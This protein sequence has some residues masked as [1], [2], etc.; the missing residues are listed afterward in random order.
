MQTIGEKI[1]ELRKG[2]KMTQEQL[3]E[4]MHVSSQ[5]VSKWENDLSIPDLP[6]LV[7]LADYFQVSL[8]EIVRP[9]KEQPVRYVDQVTKKPMEQMTLHIYVLSS[10][11]DKVKI[12]L[13]MGLVKVA[14]ET[15]MKMPNM[16][17]NESL[18]EIDFEQIYAMV[19]S[20]LIGKI[21]EIESSDG[22]T[23]EIVVD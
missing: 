4:I 13:P 16:G 8:D 9:Q 12:N 22:D 2:K 21:V 11:G 19:E 17:G 14:I 10:D 15:G 20:G 18:K 23:V 5:A 1:S 6:I 3:A 7:Q